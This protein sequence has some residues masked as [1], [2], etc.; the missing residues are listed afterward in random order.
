MRDP[1]EVYSTMRMCSKLNDSDNFKDLYHWIVENSGSVKKGNYLSALKTDRLHFISLQNG[2]L[3][4]GRSQRNRIGLWDL[5]TKHISSFEL[6]SES[7]KGEDDFISYVRGLGYIYRKYRDYERLDFIPPGKSSLIIAVKANQASAFSLE[8]G[9]QH[10]LAWPSKEIANTYRVREE[11][12]K[13]VF[14]SEIAETII[15]ITGAGDFRVNTDGSNYHARLSKTSSFILT[16]TC[17]GKEP[18]DGDFQKTKDFHNRI[19]EICK[20]ETP[21]F[22]L[23]KLFLWA[24]HDLIELY[25]KTEFGSG[26]YAG[27][28]TF[29]WFFG[30]D[31]EWMCMAAIECGLQDMAKESMDLLYRFSDSG[32]IPHEISCLE[33][34]KNSVG[35]RLVEVSP[36]ETQFMAIDSSIL[37]IICMLRFQS[38]TGYDRDARIEEVYKFCLSCD[39]DQD[40]FLENDYSKKLIGWPE[41]WA[42][43]RDG[44]CVEINAWWLEAQRLAYPGRTDTDLQRKVQRFIDTFYSFENG[45]MT[46][47]DSIHGKEKRWI[48]GAMQC[49]PGMYL[50]GEKIRQGLEWI[51]KPDMISPWGIRSISTLDSKYDAG[52]HTGAVWPLMTGWMV[53]SLYNNSFPKEAFKLLRSFPEIAFGSED[54]GRINEVYNPEYIHPEGQF[55]QGW[56]S[57]LFIQCMI[58]GVFGISGFANGA[59]L[60]SNIHA[61]LPDHWDSASLKRLKFRGKYYDVTIN[62]DKVTV[63]LVS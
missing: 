30:R 63:E 45:Q 54:P 62:R 14:K 28:P 12:G 37:W 21:S 48:K 33:K 2:S 50:A 31:S 8:I 47:L 44:I 53:I 61:N 52:Y 4:S 27:M 55:F 26:F 15:S 16:I 3:Q 11:P 29:S 32:R 9:I 46:V 57:S 1:Q 25:T 17:D 43:Q 7:T 56:S 49:V 24:K 41:S 51:S 36:P 23:N 13:T 18:E 34:E 20:L 59:N 19:N 42:D 35:N 60:E 6:N 22:E 58:E 38:W 5:D 40:G 10:A 39:S